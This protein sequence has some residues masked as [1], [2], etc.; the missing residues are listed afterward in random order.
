MSRLPKL[1]FLTV[2][3]LITGWFLFLLTQV[4]LQV[5]NAKGIIA[6]S[7]SWLII[8]SMGL[9]LLI[10]IPIVII[11]YFVVWRF[12]SGNKKSRHMPEWTGNKFIKG[13]YWTFF[14][15]FALFFFVIIWNSSHELDPY[16]PIPSAKDEVVI[17]VVALQW[18]WLFIYPEE[19][20]A[21]VNFIQIPIG[22]PVRF[23]LT[24]DA[25]MNSFWIPQL[26]GQIYS[27]SGMETRINMRGDE[28]GDFQGGA[29]EINGRGFSGMR[30]TTR[31]TNEIDYNLW[32]EKVRGSST[33]L[34]ESVY[35]DLLMQSEYHPV[36]F[37]SPVK[38][39]L[40]D[41]IMMKYMKPD[42]SN[43]QEP[44]IQMEGLKE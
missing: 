34:D 18:K 6:A 28:L 32:L 3:I 10:A 14:I 38:D 12:R 4:D 39:G 23:E 37:Y 35:T 15:T 25:P 29:A 33:S 19:N 30:F 40:F 11:A 43:G 8:F 24:A 5:L 13:F 41:D 20:I 17:Q 36:T 21:T 2:V 1:F 7:E 22:T 16:K 31:V 44:M 27:M 42:S 9:M 26:S